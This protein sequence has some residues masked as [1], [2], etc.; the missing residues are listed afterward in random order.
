MWHQQHSTAGTKSYLIQW[1]ALGPRGSVWVNCL[2]NQP[3][4]WCGWH[5]S[6]LLELTL[7]K[8]LLTQSPNS[9]FESL[10]DFTGEDLAHHMTERGKYLQPQY[11]NLSPNYFLDSFNLFCTSV[12]FLFFF[13][14]SLRYNGHKTLYRFKV[15]NMIYIF[16]KLSP[17]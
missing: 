3:C 1:R 4:S 17:Q 5:H 11:L 9:R 15:N 12:F 6:W 14:D 16:A 13:P 7:G 10:L 8:L 2:G